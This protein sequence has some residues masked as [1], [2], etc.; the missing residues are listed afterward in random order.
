MVVN[1]TPL[2]LQT[3][4]ITCVT[5]RMERVLTVILDGLDH[6]V[7]QDAERECT[8]KTVVTNAR[9]IVEIDIV[10]IT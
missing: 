5:Y 4:R 10:V 7:R 6:I 1:V 3:V 2:A 8:V 9:D